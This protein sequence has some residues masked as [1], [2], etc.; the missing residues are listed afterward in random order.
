M[1][2]SKH[3][4]VALG[5]LAS[6]T[7][8]AKQWDTAEISK[9]EKQAITAVNQF[10]KQDKKSELYSL[11]PNN[12]QKDLRN[13]MQFSEGSEPS[14]ATLTNKPHTLVTILE[15]FYG[16]Q[17]IPYASLLLTHSNSTV[18]NDNAIYLY[19]TI[20]ENDD[21][22]APYALQ[23]LDKLNL[24]GDTK[25]LKSRQ[26]LHKS[27]DFDL[28]RIEVNN[29]QSY[30]EVCLEFN[31]N[32]RATP[33]QNWEQFITLNPAPRGE[34]AYKGYELCFNGEWQQRY[35]VSINKNLQSDNRLNLKEDKTETVNTGM[36]KP[37]IRFA[38][39]GSVLNNDS[40]RYIAVATANV[41]NVDV[42]LWQIPAN[43]LSNGRVQAIIESPKEVSSWKLNS[44][45]EREAEKLFQ[46]TFKVED[47]KANE[48]V[49]TNVFFDDLIGKKQIKPGIYV[50]KAGSTDPNGAQ[51]TQIAFS[52]ANAG[53]SAY[54]TDEGLW[55]ELR[56][57]TS[58]E[59]VT[60]QTV[61]L[62]S[63]NNTILGTAQTNKHGVAH[64]AKPLI[65][66]EQGLRPS[67]IVSE[68]DGY[69]AYLDII[70][71]PVDLSDKGLSG[72]V[73]NA[74]LRSWVWS[75]RGI[76]RPND[77]A[78]IMWLLK[79]PEGKPFHSTPI[80][81]EL[82]RPD[83]KVF[84]D[85]M[86]KADASGAYS[87]DHYFDNNTR[88]GNWTLRLSLG[89]NGAVLANKKIPV[90]AI[91]PQQVEA[92][93]EHIKKP[94]YGNQ[95]VSFTVKADWLYGAPA[96]DLTTNISQHISTRTLD[97]QQWQD[98]QIGLHDDSRFEDAYSYD[99]KQTDQDGK[100]DFTVA[101]GELPFSTQPLALNIK[102][103]VNEP[104]GQQVVT[105]YN[106]AI[107]RKQPYIA[108]KS[109]KE[110]TANI[111]LI[112]E[113]GEL[114]RGG[115]TWQLFRV[116]YN[117]YWYNNRGSWQYQ[118]NESRQ[119][120]TSGSLT[121]DGTKPSMV[122]LPLDDGAWVLV[123][124]GEHANVA[125]SL[126]LE[127]GR[128]AS[129]KKDNAP[130][131]IT[132]TSDK[133]RY[134]DGEDVTV[135]L[136]APFD[137]LASIKLANNDS[138]IKNYEVEFTDGTATFEFEWDDKWDQG[139]W[140]MVNA[141]NKDQENAHN[142][143]AVGLHW[144]GGDLQQYSI[145]LA[146]DVPETTVPNTKLTIPL[147]IPESQRDETTWVRVAVIDDGLYRLA[148]ASFSNPLLAFWE[149]EQLNAQFFDIWGNI[150]RQMKAR[151]AALRSGAGDD[152]SGDISALKALPELD[153]QLVTFWSKPIQFDDDG[154]ASV[155][156]D[157]PQFNG[158]LRVMAAA[159][160]EN[161]LG[162]SEQ[163]VEVR[164]P[165][166][167]T[168]YSPAYLSPDDTSS[169]RLRLHNTT[170]K[171]MTVSAA[172]TA[173]GITLENTSEVTE[174]FSLAPNEIKWVERNFTVDSKDSNR[175][176][177]DVTV[178]GDKPLTIHRFIDIRPAH[179]PIKKQSITV[180]DAGKSEGFPPA[181]N[182]KAFDRRVFISTRAP[183]DL[184]NTIHQLSTYPYGCAEQITSK[185][186]N[187]LLLADLI[188]RY[189]LSEKEL[190][191]A[192]QR[193]S[194]L[195]SSH[196]K[197]A[198]YQLQDG[199][200]SLWG[201]D[202]SDMW[203][204]AYIAE[205]LLDSQKSK[206]LGN[207][208]VLTSALGSL[209]AFVMYGSDDIAAQS[210]AH[211]VLAKAGA[212]IQGAS[213]RFAENLLNGDA[214]PSLST[215]TIHTV[216]ALVWHGEISLATRL[217]KT[218]NSQPLDSEMYN[219]YENYGSGLRNYT[220]SLSVLY[221][222]KQQL[223]AMGAGDALQ[224]A[225]TTAIDTMWKPLQQAL[226][227][228][229]YHSTQEL[230]WLAQLATQLPQS[231][232]RAQ[233]LVNNQA[234]TVDG[235][236]TVSVKATEML[237]I[238]NQDQKSVY[239]TLSDWVIP[240]SD[241]KVENGYRIDMRY[242]D[243]NGNEVTIKN[244]KN[245]QQ[246]YAIATISV[247]KT[248]DTGDVMFAY[249]LASGLSIMPLSQSSQDKSDRRWYK[250]LKHAQFSE[251]RDDRHI[252]AF[253]VQSGEVFTHVFMLRATRSGTWHAPAYGIENMYQPQFRAM[254]PNSV[255]TIH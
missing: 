204:T 132:I 36:R 175:A 199:G 125:A 145:D 77:T 150:I 42:E 59:V 188:P 72:I 133:K 213:L 208:G 52:L 246:I 48:T 225:T 186:W 219:T 83:G 111:A 135:H 128:Y 76:Y 189:N 114:Q 69:F 167:G 70:D 78:H 29:E 220:Q 57:L 73:S 7:G 235:S 245:N 5:L 248:T 41:D 151:Q 94:I 120:V 95:D 39:T 251:N 153:L 139:L 252:A 13:I 158:R 12:K 207:K 88:Q 236:K 93:I 86:I 152:E 233:L 122:S 45:L 67:H 98:W 165:L 181:S 205:F 174:T 74:P 53:F 21:E 136:T 223:D 1:S 22:G 87:F 178:S 31:K 148:K 68:N 227:N 184:E 25:N 58:T 16:H 90:S 37:T 229:S 162:A 102:A 161:R 14:F 143:R 82:I 101:I 129:P 244:L 247:D 55:A 35:Q 66:G 203:L 169:L 27:Y 198:N 56:S 71:D 110:K 4:L 180:L 147:H 170:D 117:Y 75:D 2:F 81:A 240:T 131:S 154:N 149:K 47:T 103:T 218:L 172:I 9:T 146:M 179:Y 11:L 200:F 254:Y 249:P 119:L 156:I 195:F 183:F 176:T 54:L 202:S 231:D 163:T 6:N 173:L 104:S 65:S 197:L 123:V 226:A 196:T 124:R 159:W 166:V 26:E 17:K 108:I 18:Y 113:K 144:I 43:N 187:N 142:R 228:D 49:T 61:T 140:L 216:A 239:V 96:S 109:G 192:S 191:N 194:R 99:S 46:G 155:S 210:Y 242:E 33:A 64:F 112:N 141:F 38:A 3:L 171:P 79:T 121:F 92:R 238:V 190:G 44:I 177:I 80:W 137:G 253:N 50:V 222:L 138:I 91:T 63:R 160:N 24:S 32:I 106:K 97:N 60:R 164:A 62:Y 193:E 224:N 28:T 255:I 214:T 230:H 182:G 116:H 217:M 40:D 157:I 241:T 107:S 211:Y 127:Y 118:H 206:Q 89:K 234:L 23:E 19:R 237:N 209:R 20:L 30:P 201:Y 85:T 215:A 10:I 105:K 8:Y 51:G 134:L 15:S 130:D 34:W 126:P 84:I 212:P 115:S 250:K 168:L 100:A 221:Q 243:A 232:G 185:A